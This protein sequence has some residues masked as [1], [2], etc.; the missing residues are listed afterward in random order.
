MKIGLFDSGL[1]GLIITKS[2][3]NKMPEFDFAY[4]GDTAH[5]P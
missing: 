5:V 2:I 4:I 1:G 3:I